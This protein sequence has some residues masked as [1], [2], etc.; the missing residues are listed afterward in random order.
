[1]SRCRL[2]YRRRCDGRA[3]DRQ[4]G[5][6]FRALILGLL[7]ILLVRGVKESAGANI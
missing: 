4:F 5:S 3:V 1:V 2:S 7:T 6:I